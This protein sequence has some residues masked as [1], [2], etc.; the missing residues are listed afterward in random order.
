MKV[1]RDMTRAGVRKK[2][3][4]PN[5]PKKDFKRNATQDELI[6]D[7]IKYLSSDSPFDIREVGRGE[8][9]YT[10]V[11]KI[12]EDKFKLTINKTREKK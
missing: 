5:L 7:L 12:G 3:L 6:Q 2:P 4:V 1:V 9:G 11:F 8:K 10:L